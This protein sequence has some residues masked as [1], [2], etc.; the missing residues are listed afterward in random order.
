MKISICAIVKGPFVLPAGLE[1]VSPVY[2]VNAAPDITFGKEAKLSIN[3]WARVND[4]TKLL[5][6][7]A[8]FDPESP[9]I[10]LQL[11]FEAHEGGM[12]S[13]HS[14]TVSTRHFS[15][16]A[17]ARMVLRVFRHRTPHHMARNGTVYVISV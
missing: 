16:R 3:H 6:I 2:F 5:F 12:F 7:F 1:L 11:Q 10:P 4:D 17:I 15:F 14:G 13:E 8:A 9:Q